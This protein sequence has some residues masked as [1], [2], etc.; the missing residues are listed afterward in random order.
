MAIINNDISSAVA[1]YVY[2]QSSGN[3]T[4]P[5]NG[6]YLQAFCEY[7]G[8]TESV[9][10]SWLVALC[11]HFGITQP[12]NGSWTIALAN[13]YGIT[14]PTGGTWWMALAFAGSPGPTPT[15]PTPTPTPTPV[16]PVVADFTS[17]VTTVTVNGS[18]DFEDTSTGTPTNWSW[19]FTGGTPATA[20]DQNPTISYN[21]AGTYTVALTASKVG[22]SDTNTK[23][24]YIT[25]TEP[26]VT[27]N[28]L[29]KGLSQHVSYNENAGESVWFTSGFDTK[30]K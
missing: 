1:Q 9:D 3:V 5:V 21:T 19:S 28:W 18:V 22:S 13:Y 20:T 12:L 25:V 4:E 10:D 8:V 29:A 14:Y 11:N 26:G 30:F 23:I 27:T 2:T 24:N 7:L 6:S 16:V 15:P 17:N